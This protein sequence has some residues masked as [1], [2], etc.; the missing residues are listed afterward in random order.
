MF[1][2]LALIFLGIVFLLE[3]LDIITIGLDKLWPVFLIIFGL[4][5][6]TDRIRRRRRI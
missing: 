4:G 3:R 2:G 1:I 5:I 6:L